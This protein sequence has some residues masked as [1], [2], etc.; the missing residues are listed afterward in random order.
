[1]AF[2]PTGMNW[3]VSTTPWVSVRRPVRAR[4]VGPAGAA[5]RR[6][7]ND[8]APVTPAPAIA[9]ATPGAP[10]RRSSQIPAHAGLRARRGGCGI[11]IAQP[12]QVLAPRLGDHAALR[13][14]IEEPEPQQ[15][16]LDTRPRSSR[17]LRPARPRARSRRPGPPPN[18]WTIAAS[19]RRSVSRDPRRR[20][21]RRAHRL[22]RPRRDRH[23]RSPAPA[24][25]RARASAAGSRC[26]ACRGPAARSRGPPSRPTGIAEDARRA[27]ARSR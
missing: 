5:S 11:S 25:G 1:M 6:T 14:P 7:S 15:E 27:R 9:V 8:A 20:S 19:T 23:A 21:S 10:A 18:F 16:R 22:A 26:A 2:V 17:P 4:V 24:R 13:R 3:G 12:A